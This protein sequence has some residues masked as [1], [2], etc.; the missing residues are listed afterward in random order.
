MKLKE[1]KNILDMRKIYGN[2]WAIECLEEMHS[3]TNGEVTLEV[4]ALLIELL[5]EVE[6]IKKS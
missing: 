1:L 5:N 2:K 4:T 3:N 6:K